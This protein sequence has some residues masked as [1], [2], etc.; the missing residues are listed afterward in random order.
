MVDINLTEVRGILDL[1]SSLS[2][3][4]PEL[5]S[6]F[7]NLITILK[8]LGI[9]FLIYIIFLIVKSIF[10]IRKNIQINKMYIKVNEM[11]SKLNL[12]LKKEKMNL[13]RESPLTSDKIKSKPKK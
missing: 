2:L 3:T 1:N 6:K 5:V 9:V 7:A 12:L 4:P 10:G 13:K 11:D 8:A